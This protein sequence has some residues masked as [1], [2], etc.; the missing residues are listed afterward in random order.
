VHVRS[1]RV[2]ANPERALRHIVDVRNEGLLQDAMSREGGLIRDALGYPISA[3]LMIA[4][5]LYAGTYV[6]VG[7]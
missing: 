6:S 1:S 2:W 4:A 5:G 7:L 3:A